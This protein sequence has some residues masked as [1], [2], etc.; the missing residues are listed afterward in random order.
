MLDRKYGEADLNTG[1]LDP[2]E[3]A[4]G[5]DGSEVEGGSPAV[6]WAAD[7]PSPAAAVVWDVDAGDVVDDVAF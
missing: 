3:P 5:V 6:V 1:P 4:D 2:V 7:A